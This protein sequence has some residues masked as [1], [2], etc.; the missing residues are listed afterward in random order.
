MQGLLALGFGEFKVDKNL[1]GEGGDPDHS[2]TPV[3]VPNF[4]YTKE[5]NDKWF[6][7]GSVSVPSGFGNDNG[8]EWAGR[9]YNNEFSLIY[10]AVTPA[11]AYKISDKFSVGASVSFTYN[12]SKSI[13]S[14]NLLAE[15]DG[16]LTFESDAVAVSSSISMLYEFSNETRLGLVYASEGKAELD[17]EL[18]FDKLSPEFENKLDELGLLDANLKIDN[19]IPQRAQLGLYHQFSDKNYITFDSVWIDFSEFSTGDIS[20]GSS[21][22]ATNESIYNDLWVKSLGYV[23]SVSKNRKYKVGLMHVNS[24]VDD[25]KRTLSMPLDQVW[26]VGAGFSL[27]K[28]EQQWDINV[29]FYALGDSPIDTGNSLVRGRVVG[30]THAPYAVALDMAYHW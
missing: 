2:L 1:S 5:L 30:K 10:I 24:A 16:R 14:I 21:T 9:Y 18:E 17:G 23:W 8:S 20:F 13:S 3:L 26:G 4:Y 15:K 12:Y 19:I 25:N 29:N 28:N 11:V 7:G 6:V 27:K 22:I